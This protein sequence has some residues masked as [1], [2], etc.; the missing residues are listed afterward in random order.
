MKQRR[1]LA[2]L[3]ACLLGVTSL[4]PAFPSKAV[5]SQDTDDMPKTLSYEDYTLKWSD[6]FEGDTL[7]RDDWNVELHEAGWVNSELQEYVDSEENITLSDG[8]L[9]I[10]PLK[11]VTTS[12]VE[13]VSNLLINADFSNGKENWTETIA[14]WGGDACADA[15]SST[16]NGSIKYVI[17]NAGNEDWHIQLKQSNISLTAGKTYQVSYT[18][19][20]TATRSIKSGVMS[21]SYTWYGGSDPKINANED[22]N[23]SFEF[24]MSVDDSAADFY[25]SLGKNGD[26][27]ASTVTLSN[28]KFVEKDSLVEGETTTKESVSYTSGRISTQNKQTFTYGLFEVRAKVP[29]GQGYLPAFWLMANDENVYGQWPRCGEIDCME[30]MGQDTTTAYGTIHYGNP[31]S[32]SQGT[33]T[34][35]EGTFSEDFHTYTCEWEPGLIRWYIDGNL[36]HEE[37]DWYSTTVGQGTVSYPAPFDQPF[38]IILNLAIG[39]SWVGYPNSQTSFEDNPYVIDY[40]RVYQKDNYDENVTAPVKEVIL[41][42]ADEN[43]NY[44]NNGDFG[45][46]E[47]LTDDNDW[48]FLTALGGEA[49]ASIE[50]N[51]MVIRTTDEGT[52]DY[53]VQLVQAGLPFEKGASYRVSFDAYASSPRT[54]GVDIKAPDHGYTT[55]MP[56]ASASLTTEKQTF[57]YDFTMSDAT[58][59]NG[60]LE[61]N[62]G[63]KGSTA[64][65]HISNVS[66]IKTNNADPNAVDAKTVL[67]NGNYIYNGKFQEGTNHLGDW[68]VEK[69]DGASYSVTSF[70]DGR[71]FHAALGNEDTLVLSQNDLAFSSGNPY[72]FSFE[73]EDAL[74][75][76]SGTTF[77]TSNILKTITINIGGYKKT[78][79]Y[80]AGLQ[81][82]SFTVPSDYT[83]DSD[84]I[85]ISFSGPCDVYL[86][87]LS[88]TEAALIKNGSFNDG[89]SGYEIYIDSSA[90]ANYVVDSLTE[91]NALDIT[92][93]NT[94]DQDWK[95]QIKQNNVPLEK[96][97]TYKLSFKAK[98]SLARKIRV[99]MQ[100]T[101]SKNWEVYSSDNIVTLSDEYQTFTD[102]FTMEKDS[103]ANAFLSICLGKIDEEIAIS[104]RVLIDDIS[105]VE[106]VDE[107]SDEPSDASNKSNVVTDASKK[108]TDNSGTKAN[109]ETTNKS[110]A[111]NSTLSTNPTNAT[112]DIKSN[113]SDADTK[114]NLPD[115]ITNSFDND[116]STTSTDL[117]DNNAQSTEE[118]T[119]IENDSTPTNLED[120]QPD[121]ADTNLDAPNIFVRILN[122]IIN[123][124]KRLLAF[125]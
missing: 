119:I 13:A 75:D 95:I 120:E 5:E 109:T 29:C 69:S 51:E 70:S 108:S 78:I 98:S 12:E 8:K 49:T 100:G 41:K 30:V 44:I 54:I 92:V 84:D 106:I 122:A 96:G 80:K 59:A 63:A 71:R 40:V 60:R 45:I 22:T 68:T 36:Y 24:E 124:F 101:E 79:E 17:N 3:F 110:T 27:P 125:L 76:E 1:F 38:Y 10:N 123:F 113:P 93:A 65:I 18:I 57:T 90:S 82:Y 62:M 48:K 19:N 111:K 9:Y 88:L 83:F 34:L 7:N 86:D 23:V 112:Q 47:D 20:S 103:D 99:I 104:H 33:Y 87:N 58:D 81:S 66:I 114:N 4:V 105:L 91:D 11:T 52:V 102:T 115:N 72:L 117:N 46:S 118:S 2:L 61:Y 74:T 116:A 25:I 53:S 35:S 39:G 55:Y 85:S 15:T 56:S 107:S 97:K 37:S 67:S 43:G 89:T 21:Q 77:D 50:N 26:T 32:E 14:N 121:A 94:S 64:D 16:A 31:H 6:E 28:I 73:L 42:D